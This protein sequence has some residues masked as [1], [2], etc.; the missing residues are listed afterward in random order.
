MN[1]NL[2]V[3]KEKEQIMENALL[4]AM[5]FH[6]MNGNVKDEI[7]EHQAWKIY[8]KAWIVDRTERG[9]IHF[10]RSGAN[11]KCTKIYSRFEI[12]CQKRSEKHIERAYNNANKYANEKRI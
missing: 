1:S 6:A 7:S 3:L 9:W 4:N 10:L 2:E 11:A 8:G 12:E 5:A